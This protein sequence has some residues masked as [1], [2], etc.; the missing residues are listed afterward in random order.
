MIIAKRIPFFLPAGKRTG[1]AQLA[2]IKKGTFFK[3]NK[4]FKK[5]NFLEIYAI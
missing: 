2:S 1:T 4:I 3:K 5:I